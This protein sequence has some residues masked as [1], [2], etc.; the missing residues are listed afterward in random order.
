MIAQK[1]GGL[2]RLYAALA[3]PFDENEAMAESCQRS[4]VQFVLRQGID[5]LY[6]GGSTGESLMQSVG[7]RQEGL[8]IVADEARGRAKLIGH[9][10]AISTRDALALTRT[11]ADAGYD[12]VSA[13]PPIYF[14]H[15]KDAIVGYYR[16]IAEAAQ[17]LPLV[18]YNIPAMSSVS[19]SLA[20]LDRL[21]EIPNVVGIKQT[22]LDMYQMEQVRRRYPSALLLNGYDEVFLAGLVSGAN[23]G[24]GSTYNVMGGRYIRIR[25]ALADGQV[26]E[27]M[28]L[29]SACNEVIDLLVAAGVFPALKFM[30]HHLGVIATPRS[31]APLAA[32]AQSF[33]APLR[34]AADSLMAEIGGL[35]PR[36][37]HR[38][39][40][41]PSSKDQR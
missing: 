21:F 41:T 35:D 16:D 4:L 15:G 18:I 30:L 19:F 5:G 23:G 24:I 14:P 3:T 39:P 29:Q 40:A 7:E 11:C 6:V 36:G 26:Q 32:V 33:H 9:V 31:R 17:G 25:Q 20:E 1:P 28:R 27:A 13:I 8:R 38:N 12:A 37:W 10:G 34:Q 22:S 2:D